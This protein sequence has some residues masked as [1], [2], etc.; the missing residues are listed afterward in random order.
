MKIMNPRKKKGKKKREPKS[1]R[2]EFEPRIV[3]SFPCS[4]HARNS[5]LDACMLCIHDMPGDSTTLFQFL[6]SR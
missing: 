4:M 5:F 3:D 6:V 2:I 1:H